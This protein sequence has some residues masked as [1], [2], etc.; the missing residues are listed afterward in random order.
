MEE[1]RRTAKR[2][3]RFAEQLRH[4]EHKV[5]ISY[6][7]QVKT[8]AAKEQFWPAA[9]WALERK[10]PQDHAPRGPGA[11]TEAQV[12]EMVGEMA[13]MLVELVPSAKTRQRILKRLEACCRRTRD[14]AHDEGARHEP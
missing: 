7:Q 14:A 5:E 13:E 1:I 11:M 12:Q 2:D 4:A 6:L 3:P 9:T 10:N 8:A